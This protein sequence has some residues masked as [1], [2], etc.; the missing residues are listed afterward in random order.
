VRSAALLLAALLLACAPEKTWSSWAG[1]PESTR[2]APLDQID[3]TNFSRLHVAW[4]WASRDIEWKTKLTAQARAGRSF[5][6][7]FTE[8]T[9]IAEFQATPIFMNGVLYGVTAANLIFAVDAGTGKEL[10]IHNP[11]VYRSSQDYWDFLWP[12]Q[13]GVVYWEGRLFLPT[14]DAYLLALDAKTGKPIPEF[15]ENGRVD[16]MAGLRGPPIRRLG[17][18]FQ[19]SPA[20]MAGDTVVVGSSVHDHP[21][22]PRSTP[23]DIRGYDA[24]T[25]QLRWTFHVVPAEGEFGTETWEDESWR[26][27]GAANVWGPMSVDS[28]RGWVY[29]VT[30]SATN[31]H[32]GGHRLG[33]NLFAE[34]LL[35]LDGETGRRVWHYQLI[36]H[37]LWDYDP[38][39]SPILVDVTVDGR[40]IEAVA[41]A[42]K[43][44]FLFVFDRVTGEPVWPI[45]DRE[46]PASDIPGERAAATQPF[47]TKP[48]PFERQGTREEDLVDFTPELR[49]KALAVFR[50]YRTGPLF[51]PPSFE[52]SLILPGSYG[53]TSWRGGAVDVETGI[54]YV[55]SIQM[56]SVQTI[57]AVDEGPD[58]FRYRGTAST[59]RFDDHGN[60][61]S[62][63]LPI[64]K[65]PYSKITAIDLGAG[66][67]AW[68]V[69]NGEGPKQ[70]PLLAG[71]DLPRLGSGV[72]TGVL[73]TRTLVITTDGSEHWFPELGQPIVRA[74]D[75]ATGE[76]VGEVS[77]PDKV[78]GVPMTYMWNGV[79]Y[80]VMPI[81]SKERQDPRLI[82][83]AL[84]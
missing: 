4:T 58:G 1:D 57:E 69:A 7:F 21:E 30:S 51:L 8:Q 45:E 46:V 67:I 15:G 27:S 76:L 80:L 79:Q 19:T 40:R 49:E 23:G 68:Q 25:G 73:V 9:D 60:V 18:Y 81:A 3:A 43:Q 54:V 24:R 63:G 38:S 20:V 71:L 56:A 13:R 77:V 70:H 17:K 82:A 72:P 34:T 5:R 10:W 39:A 78:R 41:Q 36:R 62:N 50:K 84:P 26:Y 11:F 48:P 65:P 53:G 16:L 12:K 64:F 75:K 55:P 59:L 37:G 47:P 32:Y 66:E 83:L 52:G 74:Y 42:T 31:D 6:F 61:G 29:A 2:Y 14:M 33:D 44:G 35:C 22:S 28:E